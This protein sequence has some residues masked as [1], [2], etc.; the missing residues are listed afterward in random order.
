MADGTPVCTLVELDEHGSR[1]FRVGEG[2][3][4]LRGFVVRSPDGGVRAYENTC[5][6]AG[7]P[8]DLLPHR[9]LTAD[10]HYIVCASH[11][12]LFTLEDGLCIAGPCPGRRLR[13]LPVSV[14]S[15]GAVR[16]ALPGANGDN[17]RPA[18]AHPAP[19]PRGRSV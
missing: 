16:L 12:A 3:W 13:P 6:H 2:D 10:R 1:G 5:P 18:P 8:L 11:G 4:P 19:V 17:P 14:S 7:H 15:D 9:F